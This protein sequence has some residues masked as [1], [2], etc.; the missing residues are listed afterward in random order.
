M[1]RFSFA[2]NHLL[3][4]ES[5]SFRCTGLSFCTFSAAEFD[6]GPNPCP[7]TERYLEAHYVCEKRKQ[8]S[9]DSDHQD[10]GDHRK[11]DR[12][13]IPIWPKKEKTPKGPPNPP[14]PPPIK[15]KSSGGGTRINN[16]RR[17]SKGRRVPITAPPTMPPSTTTT[18]TTMVTTT[19]AT[20]TAAAAADFREISAAPVYENSNSNNAVTENPKDKSDAKDHAVIVT[21]TKMDSPSSFVD[22]TAHCPS[23]RA[24]GVTWPDTPSGGVA[25]APCPNNPE[26]ETGARWECLEG[27]VWREAWPDMS[28]CKSNWVAMIEEAIVGKTFSLQR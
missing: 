14:Q 1:E 20:S 12:S 22:V 16:S 3:I 2:I 24:R 8:K 21:K 9:D 13:R 6:F 19:T 11:D 18:T 15:P 7:E 26:V 28:R 27:G 17:K 10:D 4:T 5:M 25:V 23:H